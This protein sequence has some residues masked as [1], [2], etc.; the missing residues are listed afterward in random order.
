MIKTLKI[1]HSSASDYKR[2]PELYFL[3]RVDKVIPKLKGASLYFGGAIDTGLVYLLEQLKAGN[4]QEGLK[5]YK[6]IF[7]NDK[8]K[9]WNLSFDYSGIRY[10]K[11]DY[12]ASLLESQGTLISA[13]EKELGVMHEDAVRD[14]KQREFKKVSDSSQKM[15]HR[16]C[17]LSLKLKG[18]L[19]L[20][21][22][23]RDMLPKIKKVV[24]IQHKLTGE[25]EVNG[26]KVE[27]VGY[28]DLICEFEGYDK[29]I[30]F[31]IKTSAMFYEQDAIKLSEQLIL[32]TSAVGEELKT[33]L[34]GYMI[35]IK[36]ISSDDVCSSCGY[37]KEKGSRFKTCN[38][39]VNKKRCDSEWKSIPKGLTQLMVEAIP[40]DKQRKFLTSLSN[41]ARVIKE[42]VRF[43][44]LNSCRDFGL[45]PYYDYCINSDKSRYDFPV[46]KEDKIKDEEIIN[47][48]V[49]D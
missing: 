37:E 11:N 23:V 30:V 12:N 8:E 38:N 4:T 26:E 34:A 20:E 31:D 5:N 2:C 22:F 1:S 16:L 43:Q 7:L 3:S 21:A 36:N 18:L 39:T 27:V 17:W 48:Q 9:G 47:E 42:G 41:I 28:I 25:L 10:S 19:M 32:Y 46:I 44:N 35:M 33:D 15:Y 40:Q 29:P 13:W 49:T 24:A 45:C 14:Q 6:D